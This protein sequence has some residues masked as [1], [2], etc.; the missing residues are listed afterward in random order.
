MTSAEYEKRLHLLLNV[1]GP[2]GHMVVDGI[3]IL[4]YRLPDGSTKDLPLASEMTS[5]QRE[6]VI[7]EL[8]RH[9]NAISARRVKTG[10][11]GP[12]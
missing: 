12:L 1:S 6:A 10:R 7:S 8:T 11:S 2:A 3:N 5:A 9:L 4:V